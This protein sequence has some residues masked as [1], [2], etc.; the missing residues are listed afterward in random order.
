MAHSPPVS[1]AQGIA[2]FRETGRQVRKGHPQTL[3]GH[4]LSREG[5]EPPHRDFPHLLHQC[6]D[7][8]ESEVWTGEFPLSL[9]KRRLYLILPGRRIKSPV[10]GSSRVWLGEQCY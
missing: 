6:V 8:A 7:S 5:K 9:S 4:T 3:W 2:Y 1:R 10:Y